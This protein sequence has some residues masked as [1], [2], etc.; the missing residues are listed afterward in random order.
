MTEPLLELLPRLTQLSTTLSRGQLYERATAAA[1]V[2]L[3]RPAMTILV[4]LATAGEPLRIGRIAEQMQ[5]A[6]PHVTRHVQGLEHRGLVERVVDAGDQRARLIAL[7]AAG[8]AVTDRYL[9]TVSGWF[10]DALAGWT[11][12]ER[13]ELTRLLGRM[14][15]DLTEHLSAELRD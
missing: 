12:R 7:T 4:V 8:R 14:V 3:E 11:A 9:G 2:S 5:V 6:G 1:G 13:S 10:T 15:D